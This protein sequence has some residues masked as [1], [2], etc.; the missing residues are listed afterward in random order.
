MRARAHVSDCGPTH[1]SQ[2]VVMV[3]SLVTALA[4]RERHADFRRAAA[5]SAAPTATATQPDRRPSRRTPGLPASPML[6]PVR[7]GPASG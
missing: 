7:T 1:E 3:P 5:L 2:E 4:A 6:R